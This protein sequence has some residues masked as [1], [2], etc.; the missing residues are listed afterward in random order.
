MPETRFLIPGED[1]SRWPMLKLVRANRLAGELYKEFTAWSS[2]GVPQTHAEFSDDRKSVLLR[3]YL[4]AEPS[5]DDW[6]LTYADSIHNFRSALDGLIWEVAHLDGS[7][8]NQKAARKLYFPMAKSEARWDVIVRESL[9]SVPGDILARIRS[10]QPFMASDPST[11]ALPLLH[12]MD[13]NDKHRAALQVNLTARDRQALTLVMSFLPEH[14]IT[15]DPLIDDGYEFLADGVKVR[16][17]MPIARLRGR[18]PFADVS[19]PTL[20]L[21]LDTAV[22]EALYP[23]FSLLRAIDR[24]VTGV[25]MTVLLGGLVPKWSDF[26]VFGAPR[27]TTPW[28]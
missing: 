12:E 23:A 8:P 20:P 13:V 19:I 10:V 6:T 16:S 15:G 21:S 18:V 4:P 25:F 28:I 9:A 5:L 2:S 24:H 22:G 11:F 17:G 27:P 14:S 3:A 7:E 1:L 26:V